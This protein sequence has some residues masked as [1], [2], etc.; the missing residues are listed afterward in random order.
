M[1]FSN[2][3]KSRT[4]V[5]F[6]FGLP[7]VF[8]VFWD[9]FLIWALV[10]RFKI[11]DFGKFY[12]SALAFLNSE[13]MYGP[14]PATLGQIG[15]NFAQHFW[16]LNPPHF[17]LFILPLGTLSPLMAIT[18]WGIISFAAFFL[19]LQ[20]I[21]KELQLDPTAWQRR[22]IV[23]GILGF[24]GTGGLLLTGQLSLL[25]FLPLTLAWIHARNGRWERSGAYLGLVMSI[26][27]FMLIFLPYFI[28]RRQIKPFAVSLSIV[29]LSF[30]VGLMTFG[31]EAHVS[32]IRN[33]SIMDWAWPPMNASIFG[34][35]KRTLTETPLHGV[36]LNVESASYVLWLLLSFTMGSIALF[37]TTQ[38]NSSLSTDRTFAVLTLTALLIS[39]L[40]WIYYFFFLFGPLTS[41]V[42]NWWSQKSIQL[43]GKLTNRSDWRKLLL[44]MAMPG[45]LVPPEATLFFQPNFLATLTLG[46]IYFWS[47][48]T[49]WSSL[50]VDWRIDN[51]RFRLPR[52][53]SLLR[54]DNPI[55]T[56]KEATYL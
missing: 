1:K 20:W 12:Y 50:I 11:N 21:G 30:M 49:L 40:G 55:N 26:K 56:Q 27:P 37:T 35:L 39:P 36:A 15:P 48:I 45:F 7:F 41:L 16:N 31:I 23:L 47:T 2:Q 44:L 9:T 29:M 22:F 3:F 14:N 17:H 28:I 25:L 42:I 10:V 54:L 18:I 5:F 8:L 51:P 34:A 13:D 38:D 32:W 19:G 24:A 52:L 33:L 46:S 53:G 43:D 6:G 4:S